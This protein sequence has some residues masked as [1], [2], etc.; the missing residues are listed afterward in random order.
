MAPG[1]DSR[2]DA[3]WHALRSI[4]L[5]L[6]LA[7]AAGAGAALLAVQLVRGRRQAARV[8]GLAERAA[9]LGASDPSAAPAPGEPPRGKD[10]VARLARALHATEQRL[11]EERAARE[12]FLA[13]AL[14][15]LKRPL[16]LLA[17]SLDLALH[18]RPE[19]PELSAALRDAHREAERI[20]RLA[21]RIAAVQSAARSVQR[22]PLDLAAIARAVY[23]VALPAAAQRGVALEL[24]VPPS[25]PLQGDAAAL[26]QA[27]AEL[28]GNAI[29]ASRFG[30]AVVLRL[31]READVVRASVSDEGPG[32]PPERRQAVLEPLSRGPNGWSPAGLGLAI[33]REIAR[34]HGGSVTIADRDKGA[35]VALEL[36][37]G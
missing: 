27:L 36:P 3:L 5:D 22:A 29:H 7:V 37:A 17:T 4:G 34:G 10:E 1:E 24:D 13:R 11:L 35:T 20:G 32:I 31:A 26:T 33:V 12:R 19:V 16:G 23:Q 30:G 15:E 2:V 9:A 21:A 6:V 28:V 8:R 18:R 25:L 14:D